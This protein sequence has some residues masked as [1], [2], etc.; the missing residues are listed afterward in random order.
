MIDLYTKLKYLT[1]LLLL[2]WS[3]MANAAI[4]TVQVDFYSEQLSIEYQSEI[5]LPGLLIAEDIDLMDY[6]KRMENAPFQLM[7]KSLALHKKQYEL[8]DWL[9]YQLLSATIDKIFK[10][11]GPLKKGVTLWFFLTKSGYDTRL[12]YLDNDIYIYAW[13]ED[14]IFETPMIIDEEK[15]FIN[16]SSI[17]NSKESPSQLKLL[18]FRPGSGG[19][20][21][22]FKMESLPQLS[23]VSKT[24]E[25]QFKVN[26]RTYKIAFNMDATLF[27]IMKDYPAISE[28]EYFN[29]PMSEVTYTSLIPKL[30]FM[31]KDKSVFEALSI[32]V[33]FTRT[34]FEY[35]D[36]NEI[37]GR[38]KPMIA[39]ELF[40]YRYSD[41]ED[42]S[43]LFYYL[44]KE[45]LD[46][47]M[48]IIAYPDHLT[49]AVASEEINGLPF[50]FDGLKYYI[51]DP[52]GPVGSNIIGV[53][54]NGYENVAFEVLGTY[55]K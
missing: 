24:K 47:P 4:K 41:C 55:R 51:C 1:T 2:S 36:D 53:P 30:R 13:S 7:L 19:K 28:K 12:S 35:K 25:V 54:P 22:S 6:Y 11:D 5:I 43:A 8:N 45:I 17:N 44:V 31:V 33:A 29:I 27:E 48:L 16:L 21:F 50:H 3:L 23:A 15:R 20:V 38:S 10:R 52:T 40:H 9:Y 18:L 37:F 26:E 14:E 32:L 49:I 34:G 42:R 39:E 46:L